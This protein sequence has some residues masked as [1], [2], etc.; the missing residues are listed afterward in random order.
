MA[1]AVTQSFTFLAYVFPIMGGIVSDVWWGR[2]KT[3][4]V[5]TG[6]GAFAHVLLV[7]PAIP[8]VIASGNALGESGVWSKGIRPRALMHEA[9]SS[10]FP[11]LH[12]HLERCCRFHQGES[13][14]FRQFS[15]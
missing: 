4:C 12:L 2:F 10:S 13:R 3:L 8:S 7:V 1:T 6:V 11:H 5:G 15:S 14:I 9:R